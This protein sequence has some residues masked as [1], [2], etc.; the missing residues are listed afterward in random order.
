MPCYCDTPDEKDQVEIERRCKERMYFDVQEILTKEQA[1]ECKRQ[2]LKQFP[3]G[4]VNDH[5]CKICKILTKEQM[6]KIPAY[7]YQIKWS[8]ETLNDWYV[9][10]CIDDE[11]H[12]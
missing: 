1:Q 7:Q 9:K 10:H 2:N 12:K 11:K 4:N 6:E 3:L 8:Y 5:L